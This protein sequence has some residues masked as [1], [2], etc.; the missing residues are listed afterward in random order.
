MERNL[1]TCSDQNMNLET[2]LMH[3]F[4]LIQPFRKTIV[5][6]LMVHNSLVVLWGETHFDLFQNSVKNT[7]ARFYLE[8]MSKIIFFMVLF[9]WRPGKIHEYSEYKR[10]LRKKKNLKNARFF[11]EKH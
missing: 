2:A 3:S 9:Y 5:S 1:E 4:I 8:F 6:A 10:G 11:N 7:A